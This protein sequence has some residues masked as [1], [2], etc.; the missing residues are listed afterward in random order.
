MLS[1][2]EATDLCGPVGSE[3][4]QQVTLSFPPNYLYTYNG[5]VGN[6][7]V[8][9]GGPSA[10]FNPTDLN[11]CTTTVTSVDIGPHFANNCSPFVVAPTQLLDV[12]PAWST[13]TVSSFFGTQQQEIPP[14]IFANAHLASRTWLP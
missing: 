7:A 13:C 10:L 14:M 4:T 9:N 6:L 11:N 8:S 3:A 5:E 1:S 12:D 2:V